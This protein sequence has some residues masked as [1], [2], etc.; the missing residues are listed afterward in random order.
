MKIEDNRKAKSKTPFGELSVGTIFEHDV[1]RS[2]AFMKIELIPS[3][4]DPKGKN[5]LDLSTG[6]LWSVGAES[7]VHPISARLIIED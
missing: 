6:E 2:T 7:R 1:D 3:I 4:Y 5:A